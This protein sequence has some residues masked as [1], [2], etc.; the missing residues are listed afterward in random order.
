MPELPVR[1]E[2]IPGDG[3][4]QRLRAHLPAPAVVT[5]TC[6]P[7]HGPGEAVDTAVGLAAAGYTAVPHLAARSVAGRSEL[8]GHV[9]RCTDAGI[10]DVFVVGGDAA[11]AAGPYA[12]SGALM[13]DI[14]D[15]SG[16]ALRMGIAVYPEG[17]PGTA[18]DELARTLRA[19]QEFASWCVTQLCFS[20]DTLRAYL[21][22]LRR[23]GITVPVWA[24]VPGPVRI[25]RLLRLAGTIGVGSSIGFLR[26]SA[27]GVD[28]GSV[29]RQLLSSASYDPAPL[30]GALDGA[31]YEGLHVYS[32][33][34][35]AGLERSGMARAPL[36]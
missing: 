18:E 4:E 8:A 10:R 1:I 11:R 2:V 28:T 19:K 17:H 7:H 36:A 26:R 15:L 16:G 35:L 29:V 33:N 6:L 9:Q 32:F 27:G 13:E 14:A 22:R 23:D 34:D 31:G 5:V 25:S 3:L 24:G 20:P 21:P 30:V 12:W